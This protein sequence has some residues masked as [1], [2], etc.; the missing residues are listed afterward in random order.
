MQTKLIGDSEK[1][2]MDVIAKLKKIKHKVRYIL[3]KYPDT[4]GDDVL[5]LFRYYRIFEPDRVTFK[6]SDFKALFNMTSPESIR[7][8][9][10]KIQEGGE[11]LPTE[12]TVLKR[13]R[14]EQQIHDRIHEV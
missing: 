10:Q 3:E 5:L 4:R 6:M 2:E 14:R 7:R 12:R 1:E 13:R 8:V 11:L 9:R